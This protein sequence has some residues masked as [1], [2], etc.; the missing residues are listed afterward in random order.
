MK[1]KN[2][3]S[4]KAGKIL[5]DRLKELGLTRYRLFLNNPTTVIPGTLDRA[6][7]GKNMNLATLAHLC[8]LLD[9]EI[10]IKPKENGT[11]NK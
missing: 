9:L 1:I 7:D 6:L 10:V 2:D 11:D 4:K 5:R 3:F 8:D